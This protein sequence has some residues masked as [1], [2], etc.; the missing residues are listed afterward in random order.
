MTCDEFEEIS[1]AY[2]LDAVT[3]AERQAAEAHLVSCAKCTT[4]LQELRGVVSLL[5]L[6]V[7]Q[8]KP[9]PALEARILDAVRREGQGDSVKRSQPIPI[10]PLRAGQRVAPR[11]NK[12][13]DCGGAGPRERLLRGRRSRDRIA[14]GRT[15]PIPRSRYWSILFVAAT[16][17]HSSKARRERKLSI[18]EGTAADVAGHR[19]LRRCLLKGWE[20]K[21]YSRKVR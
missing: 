5:P 11:V 10:T 13:R 15:A 20:Q 9:P 16:L 3:P 12:S 8:I 19:W 6:T 17:G 21:R 2:A 7:P 4:L 1:G 18:A 14:T